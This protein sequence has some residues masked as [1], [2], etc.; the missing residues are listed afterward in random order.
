[1]ENTY[2][3]EIV[4]D[5]PDLHELNV[6]IDPENII[7]E[8]KPSDIYNFASEIQEIFQNKNELERKNIIFNMYND[9]YNPMDHDDVPE[10]LKEFEFFPILN[11]ML[12]ESINDESDEELSSVLSILNKL[13]T[14][15]SNLSDLIIESDTFE[16]L[17]SSFDSVPDHHFSQIIFL[18]CVILN[19]SSYDAI[20][21]LSL[22]HN[23][24]LTLLNLL[25]SK[26]DTNFHYR[27]FESVFQLYIYIITKIFQKVKKNFKFF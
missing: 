4:F 14:N 6:E 24:H 8:F 2:K 23:I 19:K 16:N 26:D 9:S 22:T 21:S 17:I 25:S 1:M 12:T 20:E 15:T 3:E 10:I 7:P 13:V 18:I 27:I 5:K 11:I